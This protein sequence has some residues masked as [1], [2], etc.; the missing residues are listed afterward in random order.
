[1]TGLSVLID[2]GLSFQYTGKVFSVATYNK[3]FVVGD[4]TFVYSQV[5]PSVLY[6]PLGFDPKS[7]ASVAGVE[8]AIADLIYLSKGRYPFEYIDGIDWDLLNSCAEIYDYSLV[9]KTVE[10]LKERHA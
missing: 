4:K 10:A 6:N 5:K 3:S 1:V 7:K 8:R 9:P 2:A